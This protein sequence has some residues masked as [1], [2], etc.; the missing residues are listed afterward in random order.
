MKKL[1]LIGAGG[2]AKS[3]LDILWAMPSFPYSIELIDDYSTQ[4]IR[5]LPLHKTIPLL[6][7]DDRLFIAIGDNQ[8]R[9]NK[10]EQ[11]DPN[12][13]YSVHSSEAYLGYG[14]SLGYGVLIAHHVHLGPEVVIGNN[15]II[16]TGAL[17]EHEVHIGQH[18]HI[19]PSVSIAGQVKIGDEVMIGLGSKVLNNVEIASKVKI[20]AGSVVTQSLLNPG[21][22]M[23]VP[24]RLVS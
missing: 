16:N 20:A 6:E 3:V 7:K 2:H 18:C 17:V 22:Y 14:V 21:L 9:K 13:F 15:T 10:F 24:A 1:Y 8:I 5:D 4:T 11:F 19:A 23:G 12:L